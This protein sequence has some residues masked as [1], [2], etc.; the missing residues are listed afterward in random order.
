MI[1]QR[2]VIKE[3]KVIG[4]SLRTDAM[5]VL[6]T[7][8]KQQENPEDVLKTISNKIA[9]QVT[10][11]GFI[12]VQ[13]INIAISEL[14][15]TETEH[16]SNFI[17][18]FGA[19]DTPLLRFD[20]SRKLY[21][22]DQARKGYLSTVKEK[23]DMLR[24]RLQIVRQR[25]LRNDAFC[26]PILEYS[27]Q[28]YIKITSIESLIGTTDPC[29]LLGSLYRGDK[30][31]LYIEDLNGRVQC[32]ISKTKWNKGI[33]TENCIVIA[34]GYMEDDVFMITQIGFPPS[35]SRAQS[36]SL[37][38]QISILDFA[39][40][41]AQNEYKSTMMVILQEVFLD[42][43]NVLTRL[44]ILF[45]GI[46]EVHSTPLFIFI[47]NFISKDHSLEGES[48]DPSYV[49]SAFDSFS[50]IIQKY[51][52]IAEKSRFIIIPGPHDVGNNNLIPQN[53]IPHFFTSKLEQVC[54][55]ITFTTNPCRIRYFTQEIV[56]FKDELIKKFRNNYL[57][58]YEEKD[59]D[60]IE[61]LVKT[62]MEQSHL[63][64]LP[65]NVSSPIYKY[66]P[67]LR[68]FPLPDILVLADHHSGYIRGFE[69]CNVVSPGLFSADS[70][71]LVYRPLEDKAEFSVIDT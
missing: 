64:P 54:K 12:D 3:F 23:T 19:F 38:K 17:N 11:D 56:I 62:I 47:G 5:K 27:K 70:T 30:D 40:N 9:S 6:L 2:D 51:P 67:F 42:E 57:K 35:E 41:K 61:L 13:S 44:D 52:E 29:I 43:Q 16:L 8:L 59:V 49:K 10:S 34:E 28:P 66:D 68:L 45:K 36:L 58:I 63:C 46:A 32:N 71:F 69:D 53:R 39:P 50:N 65:A 37:L 60:Y 24:E 7:F 48:F 20:A 4:R 25:V 26:P 1:Q 33:F 21:Y 31:D 14:T 22:T 15:K 55:N 18:V